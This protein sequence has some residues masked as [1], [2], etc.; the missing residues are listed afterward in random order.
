ML[1]GTQ[2]CMLQLPAHERHHYGKQECVLVTYVQ[3]MQQEEP[4]EA[5]MN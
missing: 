2:H 1:G 3:V 5:A 4:P